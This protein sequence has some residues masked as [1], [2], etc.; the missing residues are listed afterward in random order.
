MRQLLENETIINAS[1]INVLKSVTQ[2]ADNEVISIADKF[3]P[4]IEYY[5]NQMAL[6]E[7]NEELQARIQKASLYFQGKLKGQ[8]LKNLQGITIIC[9]NKSVKKVIT[10]SL[11]TLEKELF[12]KNFC[13]TA[14]EKAFSPVA[15]LRAKA[16]AELDFKAVLKTPVAPDKSS[17]SK[18][19]DHPNLYFALKQWRDNTAANLGA[20]EYMILPS[21]ALIALS[22]ELPTTTPALKRVK[23]IGEA[24]IKQFG[25]EIINII[26]NYCAEQH[27]IKPFIAEL[28]LP[29]VE[30]APKID[31]KRV[32]YDLFKSGKTMSE[33]ALERG[34]VVSTI[35]GHLG[36]FVGTGDLQITALM[37]EEKIKEIATFYKDNDTRAKLAAK[38]HF[39]EKYSYPELQMVVAH[40]EFLEKEMGS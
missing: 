27:I 16:N 39:G 20:E 19:V 38:T 4:Q 5:F 35:E 26:E 14:C 17:I 22:N 37:S 30:K 6:P 36:H 21:K 31:T 25:A 3:R 18:D 24:K 10:E 1:V 15:Y 13:F 29:K 40:L 7:N 33:I 28:E 12:T 2:D 32:S 9:D 34:F 23:G 8:L 11:L